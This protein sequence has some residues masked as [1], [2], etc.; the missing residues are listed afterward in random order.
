MLG[1]RGSY[2]RSLDQQGRL[3]IPPNFRKNA[4]TDEF[5][6]TLREDFNE[7][8]DKPL[9]SLVLFT[10][11]RWRELEEDYKKE[12]KSF[13]G[14][15]A[16]RDLIRS[17]SYNVEECALDKQG[18]LSVPKE[19]REMAGIKKEVLIGGAIDRIEVWAISVWEKYDNQRRK[20]RNVSLKG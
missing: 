17:V 10:S 7:E 20:R 3:I 8:E 1:F 18:R 15:Q 9:C 13:E 12:K 19:L 5:I 16:A 4:E 2:R 14:S 11:Q 6:V